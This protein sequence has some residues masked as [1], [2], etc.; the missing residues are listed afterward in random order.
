MSRRTLGTTICGWCMVGQH[1]GCKPEIKYYEKVWYC[2]C[3]QCHP[4]RK[5]TDEPNDDTASS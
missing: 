5:T 3:E 4:D 2:T 1:D